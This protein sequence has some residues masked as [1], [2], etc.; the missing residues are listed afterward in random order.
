MPG[1]HVEFSN[2]LLRPEGFKQVKQL[3]GFTVYFFDEDPM[4]TS[5]REWIGHFRD[6]HCRFIPGYFE[7]DSMWTAN[8]EISLFSNM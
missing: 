6:V 3:T 1:T 4:W 5:C 7:D 8:I 2:E